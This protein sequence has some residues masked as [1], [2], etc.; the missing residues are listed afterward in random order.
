MLYHTISTHAPARGATKQKGEQGHGEKYFNPRSRTGSDIT[1]SASAWAQTI[2]THAPARGAT[3]LVLREIA[4]HDAFQ[5][6]LPHG[7][8]RY[9]FVTDITFV[10]FQPTLPHGERRITSICLPL[11]RY[12]N[13]RSRTGSDET[14]RGT[15]T[16]RK[17]FQPT[18]PH[19]ERHHWERV[20]MGAD[21]FNPRSRTGSDSSCPAG[22]S[23]S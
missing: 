20:G 10:Q 21:N 1:G 19:G 15:R 22:N 2:S 12:F 4:L 5:P 17:I 9:Y 8:R 23:A 11:C 18:L 13:P 14:E 7:E 6:T 16:W 3:H